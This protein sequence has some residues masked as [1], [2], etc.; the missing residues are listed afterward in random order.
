MAYVAPS[1]IEQVK[2]KVP[3]PED[4]GSQAVLDYGKVLSA[5][6]VETLEEELKQLEQSTGWKLRVVTGYGPAG[7]P[8]PSALQKYWKADV[9]TIVVSIDEFKGNVLEFYYD[10]VN[11][12]GLK[13][14]IP[15]N[16]FQELRGRYGN[17]YFLREEG[18]EAA[19]VGVT[20]VLNGCLMRGGCNFV[21]GLSEQQR[22]FSL[23]AITSGAFLS[24]A[25]LRNPLSRWTYIF[26]FIW[27]PWIGLFGFYPLYIRQPDDLTPL[28]QN[29]GI[30]AVCFGLTY[31]TPVLGSVSLPAFLKPADSKDADKDDA[32]VTA[33]A[34]SAPPAS[35]GSAEGTDSKG[36]A[37]NATE[38][39][40]SS[41]ASKRH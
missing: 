40:A 24:G 10:S 12:S 27:G 19:V 34:S 23:I 11:P 17:V 18:T 22:Q 25:V 37:S 32:D 36:A 30:F 38:G 6:T 28:F 26:L 15:K 16:V 5:S 41:G 4:G 8:S 13:S 21:P 2:S 31:L 9:N 20:G 39:D 35:S 3:V 14:I 33:A 29:L 7:T 1:R